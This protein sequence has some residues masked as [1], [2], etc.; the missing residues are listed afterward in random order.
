M[1]ETELLRIFT[2]IS[3]SDYKVYCQRNI[4][5]VKRLQDYLAQGSAFITLD[6]VYLGGDKGLLQQF[7][8]AGYRVRPVNRGRKSE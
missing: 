7:R 4:E 6:A 2:S 1:K 8:A 3:F 5:W